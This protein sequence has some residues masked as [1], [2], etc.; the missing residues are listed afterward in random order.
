MRNKL[1]FI[2]LAFCAGFSG[3]FAG[4]AAG[5]DA[6]S[7]EAPAQ[8]WA[9]EPFLV[10]V[11]SRQ[12]LPGVQAEWRGKKFFVARQ[13]AASTENDPNVLCEFLLSVPLNAGEKSLTLVVGL[14]NGKAGPSQALSLPVR[15]REYPVQSLTVE[16]KYVTPDP[17]LSE[18]IE[19]ERKKTAAVL[20]RISPEQFLAFPL[21]RPVPGTVSS[22]YGLR[23]IFN[24]QPRSQ[25]K[26][27]DLRA[28]QGD[29]VK[30]CAAGRVVLA[31]EQYFAGNCVIVDHGLGVY[32]LYM[33]LSA[34]KVREGQAV[35][36]DEIL[37][38]VGS[39]G[40]VTGPHLHLSLA[41]LGEI[42]NP[43]P[44][45]PDMPPPLEE[46]PKPQV[47]A[48]PRGSGTTSLYENSGNLSPA[49]K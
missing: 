49:K 26:G 10:K 19:R 29:P 47:K 23:R 5:E 2:L 34:F 33:H 43:A 25:H 45:L 31:E 20:S 30:A 46:K 14:G 41:V 16:Q 9:G 27:L 1:L 17:S 3:A 12:D 21:S 8:I 24:N 44:L 48:A 22:V 36:K 18:R 6:I 28:A 37:G 42:V 7:V 32:T 15:K 4:N 38:L 40:R 35:A 39:T 13:P 11:R